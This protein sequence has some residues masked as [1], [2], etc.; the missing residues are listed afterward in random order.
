MGRPVSLDQ[1]RIDDQGR[2]YDTGSTAEQTDGGWPTAVGL[3]AGSG[4]GG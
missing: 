2:T 1:V 3:S 4:R